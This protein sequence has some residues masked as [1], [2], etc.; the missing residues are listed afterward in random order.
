MENINTLKIEPGQPV[1]VRM[2]GKCENFNINY[3]V[4]KKR[5]GFS[6]VVITR[7]ADD[8]I[9]IDTRTCCVRKDNAGKR[10]ND[11]TL[12]TQQT[13]V[14]RYI[15]SINFHKQA[16]EIRSMPNMEKMR[17]RENEAR[18]LPKDAHRRRI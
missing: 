10:T 1:M 11:C 12:T 5:N 3:F 4:L 17:E 8:T 7:W 2:N 6:D 16:M 14:L 18:S 9:S 15:L 13:A